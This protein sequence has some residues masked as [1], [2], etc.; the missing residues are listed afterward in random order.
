MTV[1]TVNWKV[2]IADRAAHGGAVDEHRNDSNSVNPSVSRKA[3]S[4]YLDPN[5]RADVTQ[6]DSS[7]HRVCAQVTGARESLI[8]VRETCVWWGTDLR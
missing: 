3:R 8:E 1:M 7:D 2:K 4:S 6:F 5:S